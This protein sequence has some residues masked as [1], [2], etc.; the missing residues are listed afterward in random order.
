[1]V[2]LA[3][4]VKQETHSY[5]LHQG[6]LCVQLTSQECW[7]KRQT[8]IMLTGQLLS[9]LNINSCFLFG[10]KNS[11]F[12]DEKLKELQRVKLEKAVTHFWR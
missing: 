10:N 2:T 1:M 6:E 11:F 8:R 12:K 5:T 9:S 7:N 4:K 3:D